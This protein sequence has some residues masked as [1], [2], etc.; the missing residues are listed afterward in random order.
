MASVAACIANAS[1][2]SSGLAGEGASAAAMSSTTSSA[3][4]YSVAG[5]PRDDFQLAMPA[6]VLG[7]DMGN[8]NDEL[9]QRLAQN[10]NGNAAY[11]D[12]VSE[13]RWVLV[14]EATST[15]FSIAKDIKIQVEFNPALIA[16]CQLIGY[17]TWMLKREGFRNDKV[18]AGEIGAGHT[19]TALYEVAFAGLGGELTPPL[20][21]GP[22][23]AQPAGGSEN[24]LATI[25]IRYKKPDAEK[26]T[27]ITCHVTR[28]DVH[29]KA[30]NA[31]GD[32]RFAA[33]VTAFGQILRGGRYAGNCGY[34][35]VIAAAQAAKC[36]DPFGYRAEFI[37]LV[38]LA[39][40]ASAM[41]PMG[42]R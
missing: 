23:G 39:K 19:V 9:M 18:D 13:A 4:R 36:E 24:E 20:R 11:V 30:G 14:E 33:A 42:Q 34:D 6:S 17:E 35:D 2:G 37:G 1:P 5:S 12:S 10:G 41:E 15:L 16:E 32:I 38:R 29:G 22:R 7:F 28:A 27:K 21:Y 3:F 26:S 8:Y 40:T 25:F 31:H